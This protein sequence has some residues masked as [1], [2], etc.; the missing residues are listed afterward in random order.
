MRVP[1]LPAD[2]ARDFAGRLKDYSDKAIG[3]LPGQEA[4][5]LTL[6]DAMRISGNVMGQPHY[7]LVI[8][9]EHMRTIAQ[10][11]FTKAD[12]RRFVFEHTDPALKNDIEFWSFSP[13]PV[14]TAFRSYGYDVVDSR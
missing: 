13:E 4:L 11:G 1:L 10:S 5:H 7:A 6:A 9:G 14:L 2:E 12:I 3:K 8:A